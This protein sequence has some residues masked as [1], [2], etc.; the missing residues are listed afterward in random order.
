MLSRGGFEVAMNWKHGK[1][2]EVTLRSLLGQSCELRYGSNAVSVD[3]KRGQI[4]RF[5]GN[6]DKSERSAQ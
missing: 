1:L 6:L 5:D 3:T 4:I 2:Q